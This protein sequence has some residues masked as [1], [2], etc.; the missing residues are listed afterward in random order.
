VSPYLSKENAGNARYGVAE[1]ALGLAG[2]DAIDK[3]V[4]LEEDCASS[5]SSEANCWKRGTS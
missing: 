2:A 1:N 4:F 5:I 3:P